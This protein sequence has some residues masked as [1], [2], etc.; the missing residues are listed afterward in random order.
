MFKKAYYIAER[1]V[2]ELVNDDD[3]YP[4]KEGLYSGLDNTT[5]ANYNG[6]TYSGNTKFCSLFAHKVNTT[7]D[8]QTCASTA[9]TPSTRA[10]ST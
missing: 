4:S 3:L 6:T 1:I 10:P 2:Y 7:S 8:I 5:E 9:I